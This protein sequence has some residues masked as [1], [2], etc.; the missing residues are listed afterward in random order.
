MLRYSTTI[1][2][3]MSFENNKKQIPNFFLVII[4]IIINRGIFEY[5]SRMF[6]EYWKISKHSGNGKLWKPENG[7]RMD[8]YRISIYPN[9]ISY[10]RPCATRA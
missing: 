5:I 10:G 9:K 3:I 4:I 8:I 6:Y 1:E 7:A 2:K